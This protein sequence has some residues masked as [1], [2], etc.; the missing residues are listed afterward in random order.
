[1]F[2]N[3]YTKQRIEKAEALR[4]VGKNPYTS[5]SK[6]DTDT[7]SFIEKNQYIFDLEDGSKKSDKSYTVSGRVKFLRL[8]GKAAFAKIEDEVG[9]IQIYYSKNDLGDWF[10]E[11]VK[12]VEV[13]DIVEVGGYAFVT[14]TG[15]LTMHVQWMEILTKARRY[16]I[17]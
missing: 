6:R 2:E 14:K 15:E 12:L 4:A 11:L 10:A 9:V 17:Y 8:M 5:V 7:A 16:A 3:V 1:M 13:G